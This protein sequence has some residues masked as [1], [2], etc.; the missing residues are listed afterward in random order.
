M[1]KKSPLQNI[2]HYYA[3]SSTFTTWGSIKPAASLQLHCHR[4]EVPRGPREKQELAAVTA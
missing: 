2:K 1:T 4:T 3:K